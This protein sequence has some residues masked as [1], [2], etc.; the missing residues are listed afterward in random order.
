MT[1]YPVAAMTLLS[2]QT[3]ITSTPEDPLGQEDVVRG[4]EEC[5]TE[6]E[7]Y[8]PAVSYYARSLRELLAG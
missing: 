2:A 4:R 6:D 3:I 7:T 5:R 8:D 1:T